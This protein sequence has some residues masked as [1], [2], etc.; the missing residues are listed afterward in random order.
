[1]PNYPKE[2]FSATLEDIAAELGVTRQRVAQIEQNALRKLA[3]WCRANDVLLEDLIPDERPRY[4]LHG[5]DYVHPKR[6]AD[7]QNYT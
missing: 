2:Y 5:T 7:E 6:G 3:R 4:K 1:M